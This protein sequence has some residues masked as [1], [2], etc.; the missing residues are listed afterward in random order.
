MT[1]AFLGLYRFEAGS[2]DPITLDAHAVK[3]DWANNISWSTMPGVDAGVAASTQVSGTGA[4]WVEWDITVLLN[5]WLNGSRAN[6]G[7]AIYDHGSGVY[8][9]FTSSRNETATVP[10]FI[11]FPRDPAFRPYI[12][13]EMVPEPSALALIALGFAAVATRR[14]RRAA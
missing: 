12:R 5:A 9:R 7:V 13:G 10:D 1:S 4:T 3:E 2:V 6:Y 11:N 8:Q 14:F